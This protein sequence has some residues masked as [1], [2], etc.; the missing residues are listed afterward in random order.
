M[1]RLLMGAGALLQIATLARPSTAQARWQLVEDLRIGG[2]QSDMTIFS[3]IRGVVAGPKGHIFVLDAKPQEIRMFDASGKFVSLAARRGSGPGELAHGNGVLLLNDELWVNDQR[4]GRWSAYS[5]TDGKFTRQVMLPITFYGYL[6][7]AGFDPEGRILDP[8]YIRDNPADKSP[9][10]PQQRRIRRV[11]PDG[12]VVDT[13]GAPECT[14]RNLP[15]KTNFTG[16]TP[17]RN[18]RGGGMMTMSI[19]Y[20]PRPQT[21]F[22]GRGAY[23]C[24]P[25]DEYVLLHRS[26]TK[27]DTLHAVR[28]TYARIPVTRAERDSTVESAKKSL[29]RYEQIDVDYSLIPDTKPVFQRL[30]VDDRSQLWARKTTPGGTPPTFDVYDGNGRLV[31]TVTTT[32]RFA[33]LP[34]YFRGEYAYGVVQ[35]AD[36]VPYVVRARIVRTPR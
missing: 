13:I 16:S 19:P 17:S 20:F 8:I 33:Y 3:D 23:W 29:G 22:D 27:P 5:A 30:D 34:M 21:A 32:L 14:L 12:T 11:R 1:R 25:N 2:D 10:A 15:T 4:N 6:W 28:Q 35:D 7:D 36:D 31:A 26:L 24:A 9:Q 18:G